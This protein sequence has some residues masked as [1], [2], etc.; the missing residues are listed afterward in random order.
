[1]A[2]VSL[3]K[4]LGQFSPLKRKEKEKKMK[5]KVEVLGGKDNYINIA[6]CQIDSEGNDQLI[7]DVY[8]FMKLE[9][10]EGMKI[11]WDK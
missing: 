1:M 2:I 3:C 9:L 11:K 4:Q 10:P 8:P 7:E 6:I 5:I